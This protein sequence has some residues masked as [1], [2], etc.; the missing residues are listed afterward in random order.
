M[1]PIDSTLLDDSSKFLSRD[2]S[3]FIDV[4]IVENMF[5]ELFIV[6]VRSLQA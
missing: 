4:K 5:Q 1:I 3:I 6:K 2:R